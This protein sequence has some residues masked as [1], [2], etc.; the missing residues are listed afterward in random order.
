MTPPSG[1]GEAALSRRAFVGAAGA[2][3]AAGLLGASPAGLR[4]SLA[5]AA[6]ARGAAAPAWEVLT[7]EQAAAVEAL[8]SRIL[9]TDDTPGAREA[10]VVFFVDHALA[11]W[12][13]PQRAFLLAGVADLDRRAALR[14]AP[15]FAELPGEG[16][17]A[18]LREVEATPFFGAARFL[19]LLGMFSLPA[20]RGNRGQAGWALI[21]YE[22]RPEWHPPFGHYDAAL[23]AEAR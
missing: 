20:H 15:R 1:A 4:A 2:L 18:V 14:G 3:C 23:S 17:V 13:A 11:T 22:H 16:Q 9:P 6:R 10:G 21:G 12:A 8:T 19:T 7:P 5:H